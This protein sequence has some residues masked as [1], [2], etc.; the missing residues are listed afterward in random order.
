MVGRF[1]LPPE[2]VRLYQVAL[3][4]Y[5]KGEYTA[6]LNRVAA[7]AEIDHGWLQRQLLHSY[8][9]RSLGDTIGRDGSFAGSADDGC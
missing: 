4:H 5:R 2:A 1:T 7:L 9:L 3:A 8:I 6:C